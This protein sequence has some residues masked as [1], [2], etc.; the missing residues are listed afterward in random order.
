[1]GRKIK[2]ATRCYCDTFAHKMTGDGCDMCNPEYADELWKEAER[3]GAKNT[4]QANQ[5]GA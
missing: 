5:P 4:E 2:P 1:M 3:E